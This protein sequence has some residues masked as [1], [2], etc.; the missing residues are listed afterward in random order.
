MRLSFKWNEKGRWK[1]M[2]HTPMGKYPASVAKQ[3]AV[4]ICAK[5]GKGSVFIRVTVR[6]PEYLFDSGGTYES[7]WH[8]VYFV[9]V[10]KKT[11]TVYTPRIRKVVENTK[12]R[13][14]Y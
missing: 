4:E 3:A 13:K 12:K 7:M 14:R 2:R 9:E 1:K 10:S 6:Y 5:N 8:T 11:A